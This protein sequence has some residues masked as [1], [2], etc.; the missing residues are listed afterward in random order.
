LVYN[1][2]YCADGVGLT[3]VWSDI[4]ALPHN[5]KEKQSIRHK[6]HYFYVIV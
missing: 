4:P 5:S 3:D 1:D 6:N 2:V